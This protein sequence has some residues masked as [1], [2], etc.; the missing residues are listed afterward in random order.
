MGNFIVWDA[1]NGKIVQSKDEK[2]SVWSGALVTEG[3]IAC[4]GTLEGYLKCVDANGV[5]K[6]LFKFKTPSGIIGNVFTYMY[7]GKQ[8]IG[9]FSGIGGWAGIGMAAG[10]EKDQDGLAPWAATRNSRPYGAGRFA[11]G[12]RVAAIAR[13]Q[14]ITES[15]AWQAPRRR[16]FVC[17]TPSNLA[18]RRQSYDQSRFARRADPWRGTM[19]TLVTRQI[20]ALVLGA[21]LIAAVDSTAQDKPPAAADSKLYTVVDGYKVDANTMNGCAL[22]RRRVTASRCEQGMGAHP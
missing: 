21:S 5:N 3:G 19:R 15:P 9:V 6:D 20:V 14:G 18:A 16:F 4:F 22:A 10:L 7:K 1:G 12:L 11:D 13:K 17:G 2:F 8:Y